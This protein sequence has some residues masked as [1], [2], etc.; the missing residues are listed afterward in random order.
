MSLE[1]DG[2]CIPAFARNSS[3]LVSLPEVS[4]GEIEPN[5][6]VGSLSFLI[7]RLSWDGNSTGQLQDLRRL[8]FALKLLLRALRDGFW[9]M[10]RLRG[11]LDSLLLFDELLEPWPDESEEECIL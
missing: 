8:L 6:L 10:L 9:K 11:D 2:D 5:L 1:E 7:R 3:T 4:R